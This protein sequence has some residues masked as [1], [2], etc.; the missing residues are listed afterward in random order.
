MNAG[1]SGYGIISNINRNRVSEGTANI[2]AN[3]DFSHI[4]KRS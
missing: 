4:L 3:L 1:F 2:Y